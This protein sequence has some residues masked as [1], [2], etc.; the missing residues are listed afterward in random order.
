MGDDQPE[1]ADQIERA[2]MQW[3]TERPELDTSPME[4]F[5]RLS[6]VQHLA[7]RVVTETLA[8]HGLTLAGFDVLASL[9]RSG[10]PYRCTPSEL[11]RISLLS[12]GGIT[13]RLDR[14]ESAGLI[15]RERDEHDRRVLYS[16]L[17][18]KGLKVI[19]AALSAHF[20][21]EEGRL[22]P[23]SRSDRET[24][25]SLLRRLENVLAASAE[26]AQSALA[27]SRAG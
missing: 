8:E 26:E 21:N 16:K 22:A 17:T 5:A 3:R 4:I 15:E 19:D 14:L 18:K 10:P 13:F 27:H 20:E 2:R 25:G 7:Q 6:R 24:L 9:R 1:I 11:A 23:M 12:T